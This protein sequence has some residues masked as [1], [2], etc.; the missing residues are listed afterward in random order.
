MIETT[1][2]VVAAGFE[3]LAEAFRSGFTDHPGMGAALSVLHRGE[4]VVDLWGGLADA[5]TDTPWTDDTLSVIFSCTKGLMAILAAQL[6]DEGLLDYEAPVSRYWPEFA[7]AGKGGVLVRHLVTHQSGISAPREIMYLAD[8]LNWARATGILAAQ[9]PLWTPGEGYSYH[10]LTQGWLIGEVIRRITGESVGDVFQRMIALPLGVE[11][12]IGLPPAQEHRV[13]HLESGPTMEA[14]VARQAAERDESA[15]DWL[16]R[17]MTLGGAFDPRL[18]TEDGG[19]NAPAVHEAQIPG[20]GGIAT[21]R[22]LAT[23]WSAT[24]TPVA[25]RLLV[26]PETLATAV[27]VQTEGAPVFAVPPPWPRWG[28]GFQLDSEA[29]RYLTPRG[30]GHDGAGGQVAFADPELEIGFAYVTNLMEA[31][32]PRATAVIDA[33]RSVLGVERPSA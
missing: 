14:L 28:M 27:A 10:S 12:W 33:L 6:V 19:F 2:G 20:A 3:P 15:V 17:A 24:V 18:I 13:A 26:S 23:I 5:R 11:A 22:A 32:D 8:A 31:D 16:D 30:F 29:R 25:G 1:S 21:A 9:E 4:V 7:Q